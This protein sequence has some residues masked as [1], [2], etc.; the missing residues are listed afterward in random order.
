MLSGSRRGGLEN[1]GTHP[2]RGLPRAVGT[3]EYDDDVVHGV[4]IILIEEAP[5]RIAYDRFLV[6][7]GNQAQKA[8]SR[9][10]LGYIIGS[11]KAEEHEAD[12]RDHPQPIDDGCIDVIYPGDIERAHMSA[13]P[14]VGKAARDAR[15][16][17]DRDE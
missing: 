13:P 9:R 10:F 16:S 14:Q 5:D 7:G 3:V 15:E 4:G 12:D 6:V 8:C 11:A 17:A 1:G 2:S